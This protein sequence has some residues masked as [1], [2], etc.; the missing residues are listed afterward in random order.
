MD[1]MEITAAL[2]NLIQNERISS[3][4]EGLDEERARC[5]KVMRDAIVNSSS[6]PLINNRLREIESLILHP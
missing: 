5:G 2:A 3:F 4:N 1:F 6:E